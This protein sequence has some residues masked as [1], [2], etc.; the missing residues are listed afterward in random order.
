MRFTVVPALLLTLVSCVTPATAPIAPAASAGTAAPCRPGDAL[1]NAA[2]WMQSAAEYRASALQAYALGTRQLDAALADPT[3]TAIPGSPSTG[4]PPAIILD[5]DETTLDNS[6]FEARMVRQGLKY[7]DVQWKS[8]IFESAAPAIPG[9]AEFLQY[10]KSKGV[11]AFFITNRRP[12]EEAPTRRN[13]EKIGFPLSSTEDTVL[14][15]ADRP[16]WDTGDKTSRRAYVASR[17]RV[18][19]VFGDDLN[20]FVAAR[21]LSVPARDAIMRDTTSQWGTRWIMLPNAMYGSWEEAASGRGE[22]CAQ[23]QRKIEAMRP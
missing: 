12:D 21:S 11:T 16:E 8:W 6:A 2:L 3:W 18:L 9:A 19:L 1:V 4:L 23:L 7:N 22:D 20:D 5:A 17:Y 15:R 14:V 13:M 10:A